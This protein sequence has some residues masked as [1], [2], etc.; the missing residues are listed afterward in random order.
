MCIA[1][2][3][4]T[5]VAL[6]LHRINS[7]NIVHMIEESPIAELEKKGGPRYALQHVSSDSKRLLQTGEKD[8]S[9]GYCCP[10]HRC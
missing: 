6:V 7:L 10:Q 5:S 4:H 8:Q 2:F 1:V 3:V 9:Q